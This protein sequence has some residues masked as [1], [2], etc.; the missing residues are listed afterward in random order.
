MKKERKGQGTQ[1]DRLD[2]TQLKL[3]QQQISR[4]GRK[5]EKRR[6][7]RS[8]ASFLDSTFTNNNNN[9]FKSFFF[10]ILPTF[11][12]HFQSHHVPN[13]MYNIE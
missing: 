7:R 1:L 13:L 3:V 10:A 4:L 8:R 12:K 2:S 5:I 9:N 11:S 6:R